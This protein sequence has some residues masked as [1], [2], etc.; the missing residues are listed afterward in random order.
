MHATDAKTQKIEPDPILFLTDESSEAV[1]K[2][3]WHNV[4][5]YLFFNVRKFRTPCAETFSVT[6]VSP[7]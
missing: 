2:P 4:R 3:D 1:C 6:T 5:S 7:W